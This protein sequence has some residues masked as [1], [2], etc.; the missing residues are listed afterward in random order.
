MIFKENSLS[1][2]FTNYKAR[3]GSLLIAEPFMLDG[4]FKRSVVLL[5][6]HNEKEGTLGF[7]VNKPIK[8]VAL[9]DIVKPFENATD[10]P[11][12]F[13][14]PVQTTS[15]FYIHRLGDLITDSKEIVEGIYFG[16]DF[17]I[18]QELVKKD[19]AT[20]QDIKFFLGYAGWG[21]NQL[22]DE[23]AR[24]SWLTTTAKPSLVFNKMSQNEWW[25][26]AVFQTPHFYVA[27]FPENAYLN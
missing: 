9:S 4:Y 2:D 26:K 24:N 18:V 10:W 14:G 3:K 13:G 8:N 21:E 12:Y 25:R 17:K 5:A 22:E 19:E 7:I 20:P 6:I 1:L 16:G 11:I 27:N 23:I 15:L